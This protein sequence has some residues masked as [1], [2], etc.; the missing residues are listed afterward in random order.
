MNFYNIGKAI[1]GMQDLK[2][3]KI[4][5]GNGHALEAPGIIVMLHQ[6][7]RNNLIDTQSTV[8]EDMRLAAYQA[9]ERSLHASILAFEAEATGLILEARQKERPDAYLDEVIARFGR[10]QGL[11]S[12]W[13]VMAWHLGGLV[14]LTDD[15]SDGTVSLCT[16]SNDPDDVVCVIASGI[17]PAK[18]LQ[19]WD[20]ISEH[21]A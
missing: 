12:D 17:S 2:R 11:N 20:M 14:W 4:V 7:T 1:K 19:V 6:I 21:G 16:R 10:H 9:A 5:S 18:A 13:S 15:E 8:L 3:I